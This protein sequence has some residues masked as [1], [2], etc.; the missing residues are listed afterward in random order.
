MSAPSVNITTDEIA[1]VTAA[2]RVAI[3]T[4]KNVDADECAVSLIVLDMHGA[5]VYDRSLRLSRQPA[6]VLLDGLR[7]Y[8]KYTIN[9]QVRPK[10]YAADT[11]F[12][13]YDLLAFMN[14]GIPLTLYYA[15]NSGSP[16]F[17]PGFRKFPCKF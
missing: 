12:I 10:M 3:D 16:Y 2:F 14:S 7:P 15:P 1:K 9:A 17:P 13:L 8:H 11:N 5:S 6:H 4:E